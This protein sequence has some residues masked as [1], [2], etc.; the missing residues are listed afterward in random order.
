ME[1]IAQR[2]TIEWK[3]EEIVGVVGNTS[4][5]IRCPNCRHKYLNAKQMM[6]TRQFSEK[7]DLEFKWSQRQTNYRWRANE[8]LHS[9]IS[10]AKSTA[11]TPTPPIKCVKHFSRNFRSLFFISICFRHLTCKYSQAYWVTGCMFEKRYSRA[12]ADFEWKYCSETVL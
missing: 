2:A 10:G 11:A 7:T 6:N 1:G 4:N 9:S 5:L 3:W 12:H 8:K